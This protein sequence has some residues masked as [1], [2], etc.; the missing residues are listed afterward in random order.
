MIDRTIEIVDKEVKIIFDGCMICQNSF[1]F[2]YLN[3]LCDFL[4]I[5]D[6]LK[7]IYQFL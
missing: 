7:E 1:C 5:V 3:R 2:F 6:L 4:L